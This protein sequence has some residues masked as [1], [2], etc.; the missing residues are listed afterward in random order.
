MLKVGFIGCGGIAHAHAAGWNETS[1]AGTARVAALC[2]VDPGNIAALEAKLGQSDTPRFSDWKKMLAETEVDAVDICLPHHLHA[3]AVLDAAAA[4]KHIL[5]EKPLCMTLDEAAQIEAAIAAS[6]VTLMCAHNQLFEPA[7]RHIRGELDR[8][9]IGELQMV[10]S[11]DCFRTNRGSNWGWRKDLATAG[12]GCLI[13]TGY[14]PTYRLLHVAG[15]P[16]TSV[17][18]VTGRYQCQIEGEDTAN[19]LVTF[20]NGAIGQILT[21]WAFPLPH[22]TWQV[23]AFGTEGAVYAHGNRFL[24]VPYQGDANEQTLDPRNGFAEEVKHFVDCLANGTAPLQT[25]V[26]GINVLKLILGA[27]EA[28]TTG[29]TVGL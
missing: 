26:D 7:V 23:Y 10:Y 27:Y 8:G 6:G 13:D 24:H 3:P 9:L 4:G 28:R 18:A 29:R 1:A 16:A 14:H 20:A 22:G 2:D 11:A 5:I 12:G 21:S 25:Q 17:T 15:S 19:V